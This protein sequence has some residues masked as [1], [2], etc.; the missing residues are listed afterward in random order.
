MPYDPLEDL[1]NSTAGVD[2]ETEDLI[3]Q[4][5]QIREETIQDLGGR[6]LEEEIS[7]E[8]QTTQ[9]PESSTEESPETEGTTEGVV[10]ENNLP[11]G[12]YHHSELGVV[13]EDNLPEGYFVRNGDVYRN[14]T[15]AE[16]I[17]KFKNPGELIRGGLQHWANQEPSW[18]TPADWPAAAGA[19][20]IDFGIGLVNKVTPGN[21]DIPEYQNIE[22]KGYKLLEIS[23]QLLYLL[24]T[25]QKVLVQQGQQLT[26][27]LVGN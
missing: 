18:K 19:G 16:V 11:E 27:K 9:Q 5:D 15:N 26:L 23:L 10:D 3:E 7:T 14:A 1:F 21:F 13:H 8:E 17:E 2:E 22:V 20:V 6:P 24:Y 4:R 25:L 12:Y